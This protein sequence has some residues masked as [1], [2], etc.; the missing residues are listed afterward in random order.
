[1]KLEKH[2]AVAA[3]LAA[4]ALLSA[5]EDDNYRPDAATEPEASA[6][7]LVFTEDNAARVTG[8]ILVLNAFLIYGPSTFFLPVN[9]LMDEGEC[10]GGQ[11]SVV[12]DEQ[13]RPTRLTAN[14][15]VVEQNGPSGRITVDGGLRIEYSSDDEEAPPSR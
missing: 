14:D 3:L 12:E 1:M 9:Y 7:A 13:G 5:C 2:H 8:D 10:L 11:G 6:G 15:C 4:S